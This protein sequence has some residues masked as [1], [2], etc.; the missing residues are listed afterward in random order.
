MINLRK[1]KKGFEGAVQSNSD[2]QLN[3]AISHTSESVLLGQSRD[4]VAMLRSKIGLTVASTLKTK[5][6]TITDHKHLRQL[7]KS[8]LIQPVQTIN[9]FKG[10]YSSLHQDLYTFYKTLRQKWQSLCLVKL[11]QSVQLN[12]AIAKWLKYRACL[13][14]RSTRVRFRLQLLFIL[15]ES[16]F[17]NLHFISFFSRLFDLYTSYAS[18]YLS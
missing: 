14:K 13:V 9:T 7:T 5:A 2:Q 8:R 3:H 11:Y 17:E 16:I 15:T 12:I 18:C 10:T 6:K 1:F 4:K